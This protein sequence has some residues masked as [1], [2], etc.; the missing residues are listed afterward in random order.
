MH[1]YRSALCSLLSRPVAQPILVTDLYPGT[2]SPLGIG[3]ATAHQFAQNGAR[4]VYICDFSDQHLV[5]HE[6]ELKSLYPDVDIHA[7]KFDAADEEAVKAVIAEAIEKYG[8]LDVMFA[9]AAIVGNNKPFWEV[10]AEEFMK[11]MRT[12]ILR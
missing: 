10:D 2:N 11:T 3:R 7:R 8:R 9:N 5:V 1:C 4:A 12:N 6:R